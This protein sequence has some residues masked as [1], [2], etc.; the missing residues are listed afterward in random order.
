VGVGESGVQGIVR[1]ICLDPDRSLIIL[2]PSVC[3]AKPSLKMMWC[4]PETQSVPSGLRIRRASW[5][6]RTF[7]PWSFWKLPFERPQSLRPAL[8][9]RVLLGSDGTDELQIVR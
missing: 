2:K 7:H 5:S 1:W 8:R 3:K 9:F 4:V 6:H